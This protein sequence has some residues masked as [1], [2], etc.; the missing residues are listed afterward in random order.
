MN[1]FKLVLW[2]IILGIIALVIFQNQAFFLG[3]QSLSLDLW[4][5]PE[6]QS[7]PVPNAV[8]F[9]LTF[10]CGALL[11]YLFSVPERFRSRKAIKRLKAAE[12]SRK[13]EIER[14]KKEN[15]ALKW[16]ASP[17]SEE[18]A[19]SPAKDE[20]SDDSAGDANRQNDEPEK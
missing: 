1:K 17:E 5:V 15:A 16:E 13:E 6:Y 19:Q 3:S 2:I 18:A 8:I 14:L 12:A 10:L 4:V 11:S 20:D 7:A 9:L